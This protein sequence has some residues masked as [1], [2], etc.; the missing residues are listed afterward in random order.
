M[1]KSIFAAELSFS[2]VILTINWFV[3]SDK[4]VSTFSGFYLI[5]M[6]MGFFFS[7]GSGSAEKGLNDSCFFF[8]GMP[9]TE[10]NPGIFKSLIPS[11]SLGV[12]FSY[13]ALVM[14]PMP[15]SYFICSGFFFISLAAFIASFLVSTKVILRMWTG[16]KK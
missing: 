2:T 1:S 16:M 9:P 3:S 11:D 13:L 15:K 4:R 12:S 7:T 8:Y 5:S 14:S 6:I 10:P